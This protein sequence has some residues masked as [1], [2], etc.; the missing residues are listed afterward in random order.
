MSLSAFLN[1]FSNDELEGVV[2]GLL[3]GDGTRDETLTAYR[4]TL[5]TSSFI[6][7]VQYEYMV[8]RFTVIDLLQ[9]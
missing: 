5:A 7:A 4:V 2:W 1:K 3:D 9:V 8:N 6:E